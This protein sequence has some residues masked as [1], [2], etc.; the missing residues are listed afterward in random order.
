MSR[1]KTNSRELRDIAEG[2]V[3]S[4]PDEIGRPAIDRGDFITS[5]VRQWITYEGRATFFPD[6]SR[7]VF[8]DVITS[9]LGKTKVG[10]APV[11]TAGWF[12]WLKRDWKI[13][14]EELAEVIDQLNR[15]Q[16]AEVV[17]SDGLRLRVF[18]SPQDRSRGVEPVNWD[19]I[20]VS[21]TPDYPRIAGTALESHLAGER[22]NQDQIAQLAAGVAKQWREY[23]GHACVFIDQYRVLTLKIRLTP[24]GT[25]RIEDS[26]FKAD[27]PRTLAPFGVSAADVSE[28]LGRINRG[29][30]VEIR[31]SKGVRSYLAHDSKARR[32]WVRPIGAAPPRE[33]PAS[34]PLFC[35]KC[36]AVLER[37][38]SGQPHQICRHCGHLISAS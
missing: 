10:I 33:T 6:E 16:S 8:A 12:I 4:L 24:E 7:Q 3:D 37:W 9:P 38:R 30:D 34:P 32:F 1:R 15:A 31:D 36:S 2:F 21:S 26:T 25:C 11:S 5:L 28:V 29:Q 27:F 23:D 14:P 35:P 13:G 17:N 22:L 18:V 19:D 20:E